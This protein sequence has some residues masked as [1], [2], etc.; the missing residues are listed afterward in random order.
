MEGGEN[1]P[2]ITE[3]R[4]ILSDEIDTQTRCRMCRRC[5]FVVWR[6]PAHTS[7]LLLCLWTVSGSPSPSSLVEDVL[8]MSALVKTISNR[9]PFKIPARQQFVFYTQ[10]RYYY[11]IYRHFLHK[12]WAKSIR[13]LNQVC[14][15]STTLPVKEFWIWILC[16]CVRGGDHLT[17]VLSMC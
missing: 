12:S 2:I 10:S 15:L 11:N 8:N 6:W 16:V 9:S 3:K 13:Y 5:L 4:E 7:Q 1:L 17:W 14:L